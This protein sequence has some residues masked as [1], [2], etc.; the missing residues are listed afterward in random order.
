MKTLPA[1]V[2][3]CALIPACFGCS[4]SITSPTGPAAPVAAPRL[5]AI[6]ARV[7]D[8]ALIVD[9][10][11]NHPVFDARAHDIQVFLDTDENAATG[12]GAHGD[13]YV[14]RLLESRDGVRFPMRRTEPVD[15]TDPAGWGSVTGTGWIGY[16]PEGLELKIPLA[17]VGGG[18]GRMRVRIELYSA[19]TFDYRDT[20]TDPSV[21]TTD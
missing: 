16:G 3:A 17:T 6:D 9:V 18:S 14:A 15:P 10:R 19:G 1:V 13:E 7:E 11:T 20:S 2:V 4:G 5:T 12:Y 8:T 21:A